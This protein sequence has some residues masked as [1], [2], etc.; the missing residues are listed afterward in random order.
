[1]RSQQWVSLVLRFPRGWRARHL[2]AVNTPWFSTRAPF[3]GALWLIA[4]LTASAASAA[5]P[6]HARPNILVLLSD[7]QRAGTLH[8]LGNPDIVTPHLDRLAADG[9]AF[10]RAYI[11]GGL[12]GAVCVPSRAMLLTSRSLFRVKENLV[13][14]A[15]WPEQFA[16]AGYR[17][18]MTGKWHNGAAS[19]TRAFQAGSNVFFGGMSAAH[20][21]PVQDFAGGKAPGPKR[22]SPQHH[23]ELFADTAIEFLRQQ[24]HGQPFLCY[25]AF[26]SP[27]DPRTATPAWHAHY[28]TNLPP[29][30]ANFLSQH[31]FDNG[32]MTVRDEALLPWPRTPAAVR[33]ELAD[34]YACI[35]HLDE[36]IGR[37]LDTLRATGFATNTLI[38]FAG[39]NG[40]A[41]GSHGLM[42][43]QNLY[44]HAVA[45]PL[46]LAG[47]GLP[48]GRRSDAFCYLQDVF[49]TLAEL[50]GVPPLA[51]GE[52][53]SL[54]PAIRG[55]QLGVRDSV[56]TAYR[57]FQR[58]IRDDRWKLIRYPQVDVTQ[59]F[60]LQTDPHETNN[61]AGQ[62]QFA[63]QMIAMTKLL[64][65]EQRAL[66]DTLPLSVAQP[67]PA[68]WTPPR[69]P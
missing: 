58:A 69:K 22:I 19:A 43:K 36:Q 62:P 67:K 11:M 41:L 32:E 6:V 40:L 56:F 38:A 24:T 29:L 23:T 64:A 44:E 31:P 42:G 16:K 55:A 13:G 28:R 35:S 66:G 10:N 51:D 20:N 18:F 59:L 9:L 15:T 45:V 48:K 46:L 17:T 52:G 37:L 63:A 34:Y 33:Q 27:H 8:A 26:K 49:P 12:Q 57:S 65:Q 7:D 54:V 68:A 53:R 5:E 2:P 50:A 4:V 3:C 47:P 39:D 60:D 21:M 25:V 61:L 14:Q 1:M 30:P